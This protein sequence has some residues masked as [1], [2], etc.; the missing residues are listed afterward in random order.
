MDIYIYTQLYGY[1][2]RYK[3]FQSFEKDNLYR[4]ISSV[5][6]YWIGHCNGWVKI[7]FNDYQS[8]HM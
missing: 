6:R 8:L 1:F 7:E 4:H 2:I 3:L 5:L